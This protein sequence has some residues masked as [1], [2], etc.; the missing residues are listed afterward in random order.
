MGHLFSKE[1][2]TKNAR[3]DAIDRQITDDSKPYR[4][5]YKILLLGLGESCKSTIVKQM[6]IIHQAGFDENALAEFRNT[7]YRSVLD[8]AG[9]AK[10]GRAGAGRGGALGRGVAAGV[11]A[12]GR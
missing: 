8:L 4:K 12:A 6:K 2:R 11:S 1:S 9:G 3:S 5:E 10:G 7:I